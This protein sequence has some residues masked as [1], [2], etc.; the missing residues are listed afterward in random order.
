[1]AASARLPF[2]LSDA[3]YASR[4]S[5]MRIDE[6]TRLANDLA[7]DPQREIRLGQQ[8]CKPC[9]YHRTVSG[10]AFT[11][12]EC[13]ICTETHQHPN[14]HTPQ[15]CTPCAIHN[16]LCRHCGAGMEGA[17]EMKLRTDPLTPAP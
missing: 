12:F 13:G 3:K 7:N 10:Q 15:L 8:Q 4:Y 11:S 1:M 16:N 14:T 6:A 17:A 9:F 5:Q 2:D